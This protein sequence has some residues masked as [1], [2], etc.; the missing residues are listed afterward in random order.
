MNKRGILCALPLVLVLLSQT[1]FSAVKTVVV[2]I[3]VP[4]MI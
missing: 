4:G 3:K 1:A 2:P